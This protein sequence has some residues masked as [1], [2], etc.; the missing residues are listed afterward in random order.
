MKI[1]YKNKKFISQEEIESKEIEFMVEEERLQFEK[2]LLETRKEL[3][4]A[5]LRLD[6]LK[7]HYPLDIQDIIDAQIEIENLEDAI[8]RMDGLRLEFGF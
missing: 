3:S 8:R 1:D 4:E 2:D 5:R 7:T 6:D